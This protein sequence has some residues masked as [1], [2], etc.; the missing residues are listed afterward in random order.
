MV[1]VGRRLTSLF[2]IAIS[3]F[4]GLTTCVISQIPASF[5]KSPVRGLADESN[6]FVFN[7]YFRGFVVNYLCYLSDS[8]FVPQTSHGFVDA[9]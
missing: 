9:K 7:S 1:W 3:E 6:S 4:L 2:S 8:G 5:L